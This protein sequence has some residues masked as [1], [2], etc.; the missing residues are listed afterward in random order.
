MPIEFGLR[1]EVEL[2]ITIIKAI[3]YVFMQGSLGD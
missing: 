1:H 2:K 3:C